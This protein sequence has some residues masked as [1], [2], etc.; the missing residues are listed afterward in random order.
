MDD[1]EHRSSDAAF[2]MDEIC[3]RITLDQFPP[4]TRD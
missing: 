3:R 1:Y 4:K 2:L